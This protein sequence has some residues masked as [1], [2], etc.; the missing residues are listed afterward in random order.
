MSGEIISNGNEPQFALYAAAVVDASEHTAAGSCAL[1]GHHADH[2]F[3]LGIGADIVYD[4]T[5]C[6]QPMAVAVNAH[7]PTMIDCGRCAAPVALRK[8][9][10]QA[11]VCAV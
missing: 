8:L 4:C 7:G 11:A 6:G 1:C 3:R 9:P 10:E 5:A 2:R